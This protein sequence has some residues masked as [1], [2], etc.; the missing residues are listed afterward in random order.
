M[1]LKI[2][3]TFLVEIGKIWAP[4]NYLKKI[5]VSPFFF[6]GRPSSFSIFDRQLPMDAHF[7]PILLFSRPF[8]IFFLN[9]RFFTVFF[10]WP[11]KIKSPVDVM[12]PASKISVLI[13]VRVSLRSSAATRR[14]KFGSWTNFF[15]F[16]SKCHFFYN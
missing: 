4:K 9:W 6:L 7:P 2:Q 15:Y 5:G 1:F 3:S 14:G 13:W 8:S 16:S 11:E 12:G 10:F